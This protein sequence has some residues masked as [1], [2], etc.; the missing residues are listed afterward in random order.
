MRPTVDARRAGVTWA[1]FLFETRRLARHP[2]VWGAT[3]LV[4]ALQTYLGHD[5]RP[6]LGVDPVHATGL[7]TC[8]GAVVL[9]VAS[10]AASR[11]GRHGMPESLSA[12]P[13]RAEHRTRAILL[14]TPLV[15]G[16]AAA[17]AVGGYLAI[18]VLSGPVAGRLDVWEPLTAV[19]AAMLAATLGVAV[20]R[21]ARWL[22]AG[23]MVAAVLGYLIYTNPQHGSAGWL[24]PVMQVHEADWADRPSAIHLLYV[25][26]LA[27]GCAAVAALRHR[28]RLV[29]ALALVA[30]LAVAV[31]AGAAAA[32]EPPTPRPKPGLQTMEDVDPRVRERYFGPDA[33]RCERRQGI[34]YCA[35]RG[36]EPW[37]PLWEQAVLPA[38]NALPAT[39]RAR[40]PRVQQL[41]STWMHGADLDTFMIR[42]PMTWGHPDQRAILAREVAVWATGLRGG[43]APSRMCDAGGQARTLVTLWITGQVSPPELPREHHLDDNHGQ[44]FLAR[45]GAAEVDYA[46]RLLAV[47]DARERVHAHWA[48]LTNPATTIDQALPLLGLPRTHDTPQGANPCP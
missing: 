44:L 23:P 1:L 10:L 30:A 29:P 19:A 12:L 6:H 35:Y 3:A 46:K 42:P 45:W 24:L 28:A 13:G 47:P 38:A 40:V 8:L 43:P 41:T 31:P 7:S 48:T 15:A 14:A 21:W 9:I 22:V 5:R 32:S 33:Y 4:L 26:A 11:D 16:L 39:L 34:T 27:A 20:G 18:R 2:L 37:I 36:Y 25:L 17:V